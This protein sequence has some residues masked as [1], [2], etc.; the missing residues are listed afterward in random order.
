[1]VYNKSANEENKLDLYDIFDE[2]DRNDDYA[3]M[4]AISDIL[5]NIK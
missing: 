4:I 1:M 3:L 5:A 2:I